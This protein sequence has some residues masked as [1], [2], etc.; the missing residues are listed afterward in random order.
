MVSLKEKR[1]AKVA[2]YVADV[3]VRPFGFASKNLPFGLRCATT[4]RVFFLA[5]P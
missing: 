2:R 1:T 3:K 5:K 4:K